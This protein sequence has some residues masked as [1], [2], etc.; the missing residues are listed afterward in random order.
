MFWVSFSIGTAH[1]VQSEEALPPAIC[2]PVA[3]MLLAAMPPASS[4]PVRCAA[5][6]LCG[7]LQVRRASACSVAGQPLTSDPWLSELGVGCLSAQQVVAV[8]ERRV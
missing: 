7:C 8:V 5:H 6:C 1:G 2:I 3:L 4:L